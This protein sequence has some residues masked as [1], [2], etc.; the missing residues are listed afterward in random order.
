M[1][2]GLEKRRARQRAG[3][4]NS[5]IAIV[6]AIFIAVLATGLFV[7]RGLLAPSPSVPA[8]IY[9]GVVQLP[10]DEQGRC[11]KFYWDNSTG[12]MQPGGSG[13]C[14]DITAALRSQSPRMLGPLSGISEHF[15]RR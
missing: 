4:S 11:E 9:R 3:Q 14:S 15:R 7:G 2:T 8:D 1:D 12:Y 5:R 13:P 10:P 6:S